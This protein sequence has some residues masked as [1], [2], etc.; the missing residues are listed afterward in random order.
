MSCN[1]CHKEDEHLENDQI[2]KCEN[3]YNR[4]HHQ[5]II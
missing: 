2:E 5:G 4:E 3:P 1:C